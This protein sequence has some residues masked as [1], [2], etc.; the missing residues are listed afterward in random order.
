MLT[1]TMLRLS[2]LM[3][4]SPDACL[5]AVI[6]SARHL[7][8]ADY[9]GLI[10]LDRDEA[11]SYRY[12]KVSGW[13]RTP[14]A[15]PRGHGVFT[16]PAKTGQPLRIK[17]VPNH[18]L[19]VG[20]PGNHPPVHA[21]LG[22]P[23]SYGPNI[24]GCMFF[25]KPQDGGLFTQHDED[26]MSAFSTIC[27]MVVHVL[28]Q[29][30][31]ERL[32]TI[33]EERRHIANELHDTL[34]QTLFVLRREIEN[35][36]RQIDPDR[37]AGV[38]DTLAALRSLTQQSQSELRAALFKL[39]DD[40]L[41]PD[42]ASLNEMVT[43]FERVS[44]VSTR[45]IADGDFGRLTLPVRQVVFKVVAESLANIYRHA[46]SPIAVVH[47]AVNEEETQVAIQDAGV[48]ISDQ[49]LSL[50]QH[51][52]G[53]FGLHSMARSVRDL[54]GRLNVFRNEDGG[55]TVQCVFPLRRPIP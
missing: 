31:E 40:A 46:K 53:H 44:G 49:A 45:I 3:D 47:V 36:D 25:G 50:I 26:I 11:T 35:L 5:Q 51:P 20:T 4:K 17:A 43:E 21:F 13:D 15:F 19:S 32:T 28:D 10:L 16:L 23:I 22:V 29:K 34:S 38:A 54:H 14:H 8:A 30:E 41:H 33:Y 9:A 6:D 18:P 52:T 7:V 39:T 2:P 55:T 1:D 27:A 42:I 37:P 48:G 12:F 24:L